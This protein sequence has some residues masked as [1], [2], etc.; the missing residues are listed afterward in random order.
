M[1]HNHLACQKLENIADRE[2]G[3]LELLCQL[4]ALGEQF[5]VFR[6]VLTYARKFYCLKD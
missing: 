2:N 3:C 4:E 1:L 5:G 6:D